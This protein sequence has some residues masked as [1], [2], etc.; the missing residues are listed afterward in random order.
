MR[1]HTSEGQGLKLEKVRANKDKSLGS[2]TW[3]NIFEIPPKPLSFYISCEISIFSISFIDHRDIFTTPTSPSLLHLHLKSP[4][5]RT[6]HKLVVI[7]F[8][9]S[10]LSLSLHKLYVLRRQG[11]FPPIFFDF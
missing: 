2:M 5:K 10:S 8:A 3:Q 11:N 4:T 9:L 7:R 6:N 1:K